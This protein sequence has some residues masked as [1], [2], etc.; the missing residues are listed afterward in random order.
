MSVSNII[1]RL[2]CSEGNQV[3]KWVS[4]ADCTVR[5]RVC[6]TS[7]GTPDGDPLSEV[8]GSRNLRVRTGR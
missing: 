8:K 5:L 6:H 1:D 4:T 3:R 2:S 7:Q